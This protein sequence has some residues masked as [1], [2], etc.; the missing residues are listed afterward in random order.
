MSEEDEPL[1]KIV[2]C[3]E[4][5]WVMNVNEEAKIHAERLRE[6]LGFWGS[7]KRDKEIYGEDHIK[8]FYNTETGEFFYEINDEPTRT[9]E[10]INERTGIKDGYM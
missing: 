2:E 9:Q 4:K 3:E 10:I 1:E 6:C 8:H 5:T 7:Y